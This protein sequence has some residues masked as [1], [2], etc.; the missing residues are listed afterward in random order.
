M[1]INYSEV[2]RRIRTVR[3]HKGMTAEQLSEAVGIASESLRHIENASSY[4]SLHTLYRIAQILC[5]SMD[6]LTGRT[7]S[8]ADELSKDYGITKA[9]EQMLREIVEKILPI[10]TKRV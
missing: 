7:P 1:D 9:Q 10:I 2:G 4:P 8:F 6:Y 3:Q 5:V